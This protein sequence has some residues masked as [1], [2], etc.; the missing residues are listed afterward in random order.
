MKQHILNLLLCG[1][2]LSIASAV[3]PKAKTR[4]TKDDGINSRATQSNNN[5]RPDGQLR[6]RAKSFL[7]DLP[8]EVYAG[9]G[10]AAASAVAGAYVCA[11][12]SLWVRYITEGIGS[13]CSTL[14]SSLG[15]GNGEEDVD[16]DEDSKRA[17]ESEA[18]VPFEY[19]DESEEVD[20]F[21]YFETGAPTEEEEPSS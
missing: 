21:E 18:V 1:L 12:T 16:E 13:A 19:F 20:S 17:D 4:R 5:R 10:I 11:S 9:A 3:E 6:R 7:P 15:L 8:N 14:A 2:I